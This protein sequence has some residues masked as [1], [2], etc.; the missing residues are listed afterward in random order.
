MNVIP[1]S[2]ISVRAARHRGFAA[3]VIASRNVNATGPIKKSPTRMRMG[4]PLGGVPLPRTEENSP[5]GGS[6]TSSR[7]RFRL[8]G[9]CPVKFFG[10]LAE[11]SS[12]PSLSSFRSAPSSAMS[13]K[14]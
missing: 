7:A 13:S 1:R 11:I 12:I 8:F 4:L 6:E 9:Y 2:W 5:A 14:Q 3:A 10:A